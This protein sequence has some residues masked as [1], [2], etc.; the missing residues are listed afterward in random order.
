MASLVNRSSVSSEM[1]NAIEGL[2]AYLVG[3]PE[4]L[5]HDDDDPF[6]SLRVTGGLTTTLATLALA[7]PALFPLL[8]PELTNE[9]RLS[10]EYLDVGRLLAED[11][12]KRSC[13]DI[14]EGPGT[15]GSG[16][17]GGL[18]GGGL[19]WNEEAWGVPGRGVGGLEGM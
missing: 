1:E 9:S 18:E 11:R 8:L 16:S 19:V 5:D 14:R 2:G 7:L 12:S 15:G 6:D 10:V 3:G 17:D 13:S 4:R